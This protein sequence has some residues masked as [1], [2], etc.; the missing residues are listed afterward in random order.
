MSGIPAKLLSLILTSVLLA[1]PAIAQTRRGQPTKRP[2]PAPPV[3]PVPTFDTLLAADNYRIYAEIRNAGQ[4]AQSPAVNDLLDPFM[5]PG[6]ADKDFRAAVRWIKAHADSLVSSRL[7]I[8][9]W[10]SKPTLPAVLIAIEMPSVEEAKKLEADL[11]GFIPTLFPTPTPAPTGSPGANAS[12]VPSSSVERT[13]SGPAYQIKQIGSLVLLSDKTVSLQELKSRE[14]KLLSEDPNFAMVRNRFASESVFIY[15]DTKSINEEQ[16]ATTQRYEEEERRRIE[17]EAANPLREDDAPQVVEPQVVDP[18]TG[19]EMSPPPDQSMPPPPEMSMPPASGESMP[20][21]VEEGRATLTVADNSQVQ[22]TSTLSASESDAMMSLSMMA[23]YG[24]FFSAQP[25]WPEAVGFAIAFEGDSY[26]ARALVVNEAGIRG[27]SIPFFPT[28]VSGPELIPESASIL[29][30]D[31]DLFAAASL[32]YPQIYESLLTTIASSE[33]RTRRYQPLALRTSGYTPPESPFAALEKKL[34]L[35]VK[36]DILPLLGNE[37]A[38]GL[39]WPVTKPGAE[40][41]A[42]ESRE[43]VGS[44]PDENRNSK[45]DPGP[46]PVI[47]ISVKDRE[48]VGKLIP[49]LI[50]VLAFKGA[51]I[52]AHTERRDD[53]EITTYGNVLSYAFMGNFLVLSADPAATRHVVDSYLKQNTLSSTNAYRN[54][55]R[56]QPRHVLGQVYVSPAVMDSYNPL[57][58]SGNNVSQKMIDFMARLGP[59]IE[60]TTYALSNDGLGVLH[61]LRVPKN[62]LLLIVSGTMAGAGESPLLGNEAMAKNSLRSLWGAQ[63]TYLATTGSGSFGSLEELIEKNLISKEMFTGHGYRIDVNV[64]GKKFEATA[65][66]LEYGS[67]GKLSFFIDESGV[68]RGGDH[69]GGVAT[70]SDNPM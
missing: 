8:A 4:L 1:S 22:S 28:F 38:L 58:R 60:P 34:G 57:G 17:A 46:T 9:G 15:L 36:D 13:P 20:P 41:P 12:S 21:P 69:G 67:S 64:S 30:A 70:I 19:V 35:K 45:V 26:V 56:W 42:K 6:G 27:N 2:A 66:P 5:K 16:T 14:S 54:F 51:G 68:L 24:G 18:G 10:A 50:E 7:F 3:E 25:K 48:A 23:M 33:E 32:D 55:T 11:R 37:I 43:S 52:L 61:E 65:V 59:N 53:T 44:K 29:P 47:A 31:L 39:T 40:P 62:L 63:S 49:K